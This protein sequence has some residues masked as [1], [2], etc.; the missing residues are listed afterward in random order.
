V[1]VEGVQ[2]HLRQAIANLVSNSLTHTPPGTPIEVSARAIGS[3]AELVVRDHGEGLSTEAL[4]HAFDRF[5]R[6]DSSRVGPK[7]GLGLS[8]VAAI[9]ESHGGTATVGNHPDGGAVFTLDLPLAAAVSI[10]ARPAEA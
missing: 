7:A 1:I 4:Q 2:D 5:W 9:A 3:R 8:I 10:S 6:A